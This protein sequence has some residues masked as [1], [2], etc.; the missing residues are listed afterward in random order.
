M[1]TERK[2]A[3]ISLALDSYCRLDGTIDDIPEYSVGSRSVAF[4][5]SSHQLSVP[6][7]H[8]RSIMGDPH[9]AIAKYLARDG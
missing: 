2:R 7:N 6:R 4:V 5:G 8:G 3:E 9:Y 1:R